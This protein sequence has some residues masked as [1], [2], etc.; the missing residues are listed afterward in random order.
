MEL[1]IKVV[2]LFENVK[3]ELTW[4][5]KDI[6]ATDIQNKFIEFRVQEDK[7]LKGVK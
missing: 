1:M 4:E 6:T 5:W 2:P 7:I 3:E